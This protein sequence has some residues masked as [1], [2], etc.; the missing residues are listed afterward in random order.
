MSQISPV[1]IWSESI[2]DSTGLLTVNVELY[3]TS[4]Q[5]S[6]TSN[7]LNVVLQNNIE[8]PQSGGSIYNPSNVLQMETIIILIYYG[9]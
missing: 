7:K 2:I 8:G 4:D 5:P 3:Y 6:V 9:I 1:N